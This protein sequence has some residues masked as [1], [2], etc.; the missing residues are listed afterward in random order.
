MGNATEPRAMVDLPGSEDPRSTLR[1]DLERYTTLYEKTPAMLHWNDADGII[2]GVSDH[3]LAVMGY[4]R[5]DVV[6]R[7]FTDFQT[8]QSRKAA[9]DVTLPEFRRTGR[10][11]EVPRQYVKN[12]GEIVEVLV[13][14][15][16]ERGRAGEYLRSLTVLQDVTQRNRAEAALRASQAEFQ[17][18]AVELARRNEEL[19]DFVHIASH[20]LKEPLRGISSQ[21]SFLMEDYGEQL[22]ARGVERLEAVSKGV[23]WPVSM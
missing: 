21:A 7:P 17:E 13:S 1:Q 22:A 6:G 10:L 16:A 11:M 23:E 5:D 20:D 12:D 14:A 4:A 18:Q 9:I 3:W 8:E 15:Y 2:L 19:D